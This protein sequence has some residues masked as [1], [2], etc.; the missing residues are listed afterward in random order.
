MF[1]FPCLF[2]LLADNENKLKVLCVSAVN[3]PFPCAAEKAESAEKSSQ[4]SKKCGI[5]STEG[6]V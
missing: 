1:G 3:S 4:E 5:S 2:R 6:L